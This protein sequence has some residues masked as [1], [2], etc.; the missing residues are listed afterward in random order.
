M[1][2]A[3]DLMRRVLGISEYVPGG[4]PHALVRTPTRFGAR[5]TAANGRILICGFEAPSQN[6]VIADLVQQH[7]LIRQMVKDNEREQARWNE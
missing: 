6:G 2:R 3:T 7:R 4:V 5:G 1:C